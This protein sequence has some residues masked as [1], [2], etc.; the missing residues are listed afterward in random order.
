MS[1]PVR[2][3]EAPEAVGAY[4]QAIRSHGFL[5][6]SGQVGIDPETGSLVDSSFEAEA[7][8]ALSNLLAILDSIGLGAD[9]VIKTTVFLTDLDRYSLVNDLY[10]ETFPEPLPSRS[11]VEVS[12]LPAGARVEIEAVA[13]DG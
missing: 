5:F 7:R 1:E 13:E 2:T 4:S 12:S 9:D 3:D 11:V 10:G 8:Q 6:T